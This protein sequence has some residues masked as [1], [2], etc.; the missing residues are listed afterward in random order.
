MLQLTR[1]GE[2]AVRAVLYL[3]SQ[4][5]GKISLIQEISVAQ[6]V[7]R[8]Y[9]SKIMQSLTRS[10]LVKSRRGAKGGFFLA[11]PAEEITLRETIQA[12]EGP[13]HLNVC[14]IRKGECPKD[15]VCPVHPVWKEAQKKL[16]E[17]LD[18]KTMAELVRDAEMISRAGRK[19]GSKKE[20]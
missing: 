7:P 4:A 5:P 6:D 14:L 3:A 19:K 16:F 17:V 13:I 18:S 20:A 9:L 10:G 1:D 8:S 15:E 2:Y 11:R 12:V